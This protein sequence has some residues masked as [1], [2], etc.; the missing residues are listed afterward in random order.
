MDEKTKNIKELKSKEIEDK[1]IHL[2]R[3]FHMYPEL[4]YEEF[5]TS[6]R[7][8]E[9]LEKLNI[10]YEIIEHNMIIGRIKGGK[11]GKRLGI[12]ADMD[13]LPMDEESNVEY[14][15]KVPGIM[16]SCGHDAHTAMLL[17][18][19]AILNEIK[20]SLFGEVFL[21]FQSAEEVAGGVEEISKYIDSIG[22]INQLISIHVWADLPSKHISIESGCRMAGGIFWEVEL[23][24][25]GGH[26]SRPDRA[27][28]PVK[29]A[30]E[31]FLRTAALPATTFDAFEP[32]IVSP[33]VINGGNALNI[34][35]DKA[36]VG[37]TIRYFS[38]TAGDFMTEK[39]NNIAESI[40]KSYEIKANTKF[41]GHVSP[42]INQEEAVSLG[43]EVANNIDGLIIDPFEPICACD[44][45][46]DLLKKYPGMYCY[47]G[48]Y[49]ED[50]G[51]I[52]PQHSNK[53]DIDEDVLRLGYEFFAK[54]T[55]SY[56][57]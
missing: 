47:L 20:D 32:C 26:G 22:G 2:R 50:K 49:N 12:R 36:N 4:A 23:E 42:T 44:C 51:T 29:A 25:I 39:I 54:Y 1:I 11:S 34:I 13:A 43:K 53:Y 14:K 21:I 16:H 3:D 46:G 19:A 28:D 57:I 5:R 37:G 6:R 30:C 9:E 48:I 24:G 27:K 18:T 8:R 56:L 7:V 45:F 38:Y 52:H 40:A 33:T 41:Y 15:S 17:G 35:P 10:E 55:A 31:I